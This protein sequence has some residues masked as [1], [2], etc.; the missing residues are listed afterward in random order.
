VEKKW[1]DGVRPCRIKCSR[2]PSD[3]HVQKPKD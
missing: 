3:S 2:E 1:V